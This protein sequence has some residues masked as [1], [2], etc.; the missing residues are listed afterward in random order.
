MNAW[1]YIEALRARWRLIVLATLVVLAVVGVWTFTSPRTYTAAATLLFDTQQADPV[2]S[3]SGAGGAAKAAAVIGTQA[4]IIR[5]V[6][7]AQRVAGN[8]AMDRNPELVRQYQASGSTLPIREWIG[9]RITKPLDILP[10]RNTS[11]LAVNYKSEDPALAARLATAFAQAYVQIQLQLRIDPA[12][13][14][15]QWFESQIRDARGRL[16]QAQARL[17]RFQQQRG[18]VGA[19]RFDIEQTQLSE[20]SQQLTAAQADAAQARAKAGSN[21]GSSSDAQQSAVVQGLDTQIAGKS[22]A[23]QQL[24]QSL[25]PNHP[26]VTAANAEIAELRSKRGQAVGLAVSAVQTANAAAQARAG[27]LSGLVQA[28]RDQVLRLSGAQDQM[29]VLQRD[30]DTARNAYD[31]VTTRLNEV[32]LQ[33][34]VPMSNVSLL[35]RAVAPTLPSSPNVALRFLLGLFAG[36]FAGIAAALFLEWRNPKVRTVGGLVSLTGVPV[37]ADLNRE[38]KILGSGAMA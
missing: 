7:V 35:D 29:A 18:L 6:Y 9:R 38:Q 25:G 22:A 10:T 2:A 1:D 19:G 14:Y 28:K 26:M 12:R 3:K 8:L 36:L 21:I 13:V 24:R 31:A 33:S 11:V 15:S 4:D 5:S 17:T 23:L 30:V 16:E 37:L 34:E 27:A 20:L 32:R